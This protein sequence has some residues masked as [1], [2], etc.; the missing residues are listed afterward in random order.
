MQSHDPEQPDPEGLFLRGLC[1]DHALV[2][3]PYDDGDQVDFEFWGQAP[4]MEASMTWRNWWQRVKAAWRFYRGGLVLQDVVP[5]TQQD[6]DV[7]VAYLQR[8][9]ES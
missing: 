6:I 7:L 4:A 8:R 9:K 5:L 3:Q 2:V 1:D